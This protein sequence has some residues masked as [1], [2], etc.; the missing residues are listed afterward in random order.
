MR[1][2]LLKGHTELVLLETL[3]RGPAHGY[4]IIERLRE[5]SGGGLDLPE[6]T[7]YPA[8]H[9]LEQSGV[10]QSRWDD[11]GTR[12]RRVYEVTGKGRGELRS[13]RAEWSHFVQTMTAVIGA[14]RA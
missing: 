2:E 9:R 11:T 7:V 10:I 8:L 14:A 13:R 4:L 1:S 12:R 3:S 5:S 6:G